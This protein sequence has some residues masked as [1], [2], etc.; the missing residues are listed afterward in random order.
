MKALCLSLKVNQTLQKLNLYRNIIDVNGAR[1]LGDAL[2]INKTLEFIDIGH[3]RIRCTGLKAVVDGIAMNLS[4][5]LSKLAIRANF[6]ADEGARY[7]F[8]HLVF[9][10]NPQLTHIFLK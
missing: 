3:N 2:A 10:K 9:K 5:K 7:L 6:I 4:S 8:Q 1:A